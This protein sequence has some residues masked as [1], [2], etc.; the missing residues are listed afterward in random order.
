MAVCPFAKHLLIPAGSNDP[1]IKPRVAVLHVDAGNAESLHTYFR[2]RSGGIESHFHITKTG[3]IEQY[4]DTAYQADANLEAN[5]FAISIE[6]QG[7]G[8]GQWTAAQL[9][10]IKRLLVWLNEVHPAIL[11]RKCDGP[12]GSGIG[13]HIQFGSPGP[14][15]PVAKACPGPD[16]IRQYHD[17][18][19]PWLDAGADQGDDMAE[20]AAQL[21]RIEKALTGFRDREAARDKAERER[22]K[23]RHLAILVLLDKLLGDIS[24][25]AAKEQ[26][27]RLRLAVEAL[28]DAHA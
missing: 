14:W 7:Y 26:V 5:D 25:T 20:Y 13:Y 16:R 21:D 3:V 23:D 28:A 1:P 27:R 11:L 6:T 2:D 22:A 12:F 4:R 18:I 9:D 17:L 19:V 10:S 8:E 24:D 15:T